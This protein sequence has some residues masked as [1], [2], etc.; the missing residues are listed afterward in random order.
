MYLLRMTLVN[1]GATSGT[2]SSRDLDHFALCP[3]SEQRF[4]GCGSH[5]LLLLQGRNNADF[6]V[7]CRRARKRQL[8]SVLSS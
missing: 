3:E 4:G 8:R 1:Y 2:A 7:V 5:L 6:G